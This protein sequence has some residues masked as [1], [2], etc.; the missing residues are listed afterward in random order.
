MKA[1][2]FIYFFC[3]SQRNS[4]MIIRIA[5]SEDGGDNR[6]PQLLQ[7]NRNEEKGQTNG[8]IFV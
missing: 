3:D 6:T 8:S 1:D 5:V 4:A 7:E 2:G